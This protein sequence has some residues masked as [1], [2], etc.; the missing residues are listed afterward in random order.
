MKIKDNKGKTLEEFLAG[1]SPGDYPRPSVT[2]DIALFSG[3]KDKPK[4]LL[5]KRGGH[6]FL[7]H[8]ALPG[9]F[10]E[11]NETVYD[12]AMRELM[13]ETSITNGELEEIGVFSS[14]NRDPRCWTVT[15]AFMAVVDYKKVKASPGDDARDAKWFDIHIHDNKN[16]TELRFSHENKSI[17]IVLQKN[18]TPGVTRNNVRFKILKNDGLAFDHGEIIA[19]ALARLGEISSDI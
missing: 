13:E 19:S 18:V 14:P 4:I 10:A 8:W 7:D 6:P 9:G 15:D 5:I 2:A 11:E 3:I 12:T 1:Y 16:E 17:N